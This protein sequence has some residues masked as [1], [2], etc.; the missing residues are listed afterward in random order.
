MSK[1]FRPF[2]GF[3]A[4][5][6]K[7]VLH[8]RRDSMAIMF[9]LI[10]PI[11]EMIILGA[12]I[13][14]NVRQVKTAVYDQSGILEGTVPG[15]SQ[16]RELLDRFR[17]SD[18]FHIYKF[19]HSPKELNEEMIAGHARV[20]IEIPVDFDR[21]LLANR[22]AQIMV[23]V[24]GSESSVAGQA[25]N[26]ATA[27]GLDESLRRSLPGIAA[28]AVEVRPKVM[29][30]P[31][32]RSPNFF[33]PGL[34]AVMLLMITT[35][36]TA[37]SV[38]REKERGT[39]EQ[40]M[41]TPIRPLGL[42]MGKMM[43]YFALALLELFILLAGMRYL[44]SVAIS[45]SVIL[46]VLLSLSYLFVNLALGMLISVKANSQA[47]AMQ[48]SMGIL[49]PSIFLSGYVFPRDNMPAIFYGLSH[50]VPATYMIDTF[51]GVILRGA[52]F[53]QLWENAAILALMGIVVLLLAANKFGKM[54]V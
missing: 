25:L 20:G 36:L 31:D 4:V 34:I 39:L 52:G 43:P 46:L 24:D 42:M 22:S 30:N 2:R 28:P 14:T 3:F 13:D 54:V 47:E 38:V 5:F 48:S 1:L 16:S 18:T 7:E 50:L 51:R 45:G 44:F 9:A 29:F 35:M 41:V 15:S 40:L 49:L 6:Y 23:M 37:F 12:A 11:G 17:N 8:M 33:L 19:V 53:M 21:D 10:V 32:S 26:V 27:I